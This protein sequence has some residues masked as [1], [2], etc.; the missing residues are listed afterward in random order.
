MDDFQKEGVLLYFNVSTG[1]AAR[2]SCG[3]RQGSCGPAVEAPTWKW[4]EMRTRTLR[5]S[6][7]SGSVMDAPSLLKAVT[8]LGMHSRMR[9]CPSRKPAG[10]PARWTFIAWSPLARPAY[11]AALEHHRTCSSK[12]V[13]QKVTTDIRS[14]TFWS[15]HYCR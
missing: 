6:S 3:R 2:G 15:C 8:A 1:A 5:C 11:R 12:A 9:P 14:G 7:V 13:S 4:V 10:H